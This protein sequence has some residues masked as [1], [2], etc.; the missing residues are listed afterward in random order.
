MTP[1]SRLLPEGKAWYTTKEA[2]AVIGR[3]DQYVRDCFD[4]QTLLG[5]TLN[6]RS[7]CGEGRRSYQIPREC[8][9]LYLIE[10]ANYRAGD[11]A[12]RLAELVDALSGEERQQLRRRLDTSRSVWR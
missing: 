7:R 3:S 2:A 5:H 11:F 9:M 6:A 1:I 12:E 8:L 4:S 10:T